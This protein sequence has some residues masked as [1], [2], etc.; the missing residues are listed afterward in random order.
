[1]MRAI[2]VRSFSTIAITLAAGLCLAVTGAE[3]ATGA[4]PAA[5]NK[6]KTATAVVR[7][8]LTPRDTVVR[9]VTAMRDGDEKAFFAAVSADTKTEPFLRSLLGASKAVLAFKKK[10]VATYGQPEWEKFQNKYQDEE[11]A[12]EG[13]V[14]ASFKFKMVTN[15]EVAAAATGEVKT[16]GS[17][18]TA[19]FPGFPQ[20]VKLVRNAAGQWRIDGASIL[21]PE[22]SPVEMKKFMDGMT[23]MTLKY[24]PAI[25]AAGVAPRDINHE[26]GDEFMKGMMGIKPSDQPRFNLD[27]IRAAAAGKKTASATPK[28]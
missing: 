17:T 28:I 16:A 8:Y 23:A 24:L 7:P 18:A 22:A 15:E 6:T 19:D 20:P 2:K 13:G 25:G 10:F 9:A 3:A 14:S 21:P 11:E 5:V 26:L 12:G 4:A 27:K 1:M